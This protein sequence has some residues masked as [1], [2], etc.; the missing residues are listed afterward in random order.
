M[1]VPWL[2]ARAI[3]AVAYVSAFAI[4]D[5]VVPGARPIAIGE[6]LMAWDGTW[7]RDIASHGY[8]SL[9]RE[10][11]RFFPLFPILGRGLGTVFLGDTGLSLVVIANLC[12]LALLFVLLRL[13]RHEGIDRST[14]QRAIWFI[15]LFPGAFVLAW[16]YAEA[17]WILAAIVVFLAIRTRRWLWAAIA[18][19][20][21]GLSR[22][23]GVLLAVPIAVELLRNWRN[24]T[25]KE[26]TSGLIATV[27]PL[28]GTGAYLLWVGNR[29]GDSWLPFSVQSDLRGTS[30][31]PFSRLWEGLSQ[32]VG[33]QRFGDGLHI[34]FALAF[35]ALLVVVLRR[36]PISY[37]LFS[38][39]VLLAAL[40]TE[41]LNSLERYGL[42]AFPLVIGL[43]LVCRHREAE[44]V[45]KVV[46]AGG[47]V[48]LS[49]MAWMGAYV[50]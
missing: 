28:L 6:G 40:A 23:L 43:A 49:T 14:T 31:D 44:N 22:P 8:A 3:L 30:V 4:A 10:G 42:N 41:N 13:L 1:L 11:L 46:L 21:A 2:T 5:R 17:L 35:L 50:P 29:F 20:L 24:A 12:S 25:A 19:F 26:R 15:I 33:P 38:G 18:G 47:F 36:L 32:M 34:P 7:Y 39:C 45:T 48:A 16:A 27:S 37:G 9:P